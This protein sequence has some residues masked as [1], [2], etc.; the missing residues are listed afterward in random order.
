MDSLDEET[1]PALMD[2]TNIAAQAMV[3]RNNRIP[4]L[5]LK[6]VGGPSYGKF[7]VM[8][9]LDSSKQHVLGRVDDCSIYIN[10]QILSKRH[11]TFQFVQ[12]SPSSA[13]CEGSLSQD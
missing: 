3:A 1:S 4:L 2:R 12:G 7:F 9:P 13:G 11:C 10:D 6:V 8:N 5:K